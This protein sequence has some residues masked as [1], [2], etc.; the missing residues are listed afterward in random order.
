MSLPNAV[1][2]DL[3]WIPAGRFA[4]GSSAFLAGDEGPQT[5][6]TI[7]KG[8]WLGRTLVTQGQYQAV[9]GSN[10][11]EFKGET[12]PVEQVSWDDAMEFCRKLTKLDPGTAKRPTPYS[13]TLPTEA[14]WEY[15]CRAGTT[16]DE[17]GDLKAIAWNSL[18]SDGTS[19]P[20]GMK[21][22]NAWGLYDM[23]G[24]VWEWC[25]DWFGKYPGGEVTDPTGPPSGTG[26]VDRGGSWFS[27]PAH[28]SALFRGLD[29]QGVR[30]ANIGF[31]IAL[32]P[33][34]TK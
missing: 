18:D 32:A 21:Q 12:K 33:A 20:V 6:V 14:Q 28:C 29:T 9:M 3:V 15:A 11:S 2:L 27:G 30:A 25:L 19:H 31:R 23:Q 17:A 4:M 8:F 22:P 16:G 1:T 26:R 24:N 34:A 7:S 13:F 5:Q 10:P